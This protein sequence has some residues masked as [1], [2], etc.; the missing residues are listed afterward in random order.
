MGSAGPYDG[1]SEAG[2][3]P[4]QESGS[5]PSREPASCLGDL[6]AAIKFRHLCYQDFPWTPAG[7]EPAPGALP[8]V[9]QTRD[10]HQG[11]PGPAGAG[12]V[13]VHPAP[14]VPGPS[15][16]ASSREWG[17]GS[18]HTGESGKKEKCFSLFSGTEDTFADND[19][20]NTR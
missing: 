3:R 4:P 17:R 6:Q 20:S 13:S 9:A 2:G 16:G 5:Q 11:D 18:D 12:A 7:P 19:P 15:S 14:G 10:T 8:S 1:D